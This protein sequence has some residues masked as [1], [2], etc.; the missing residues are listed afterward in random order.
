[1]PFILFDPPKKGINMTIFIKD[2]CKLKND[3]FF[4]NFL[5]VAILKL[6]KKHINLNLK[7]FQAQQNIK[8]LI[9]NLTTHLYIYIGNFNKLNS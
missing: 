4:D 3:I 2:F 5:F 6:P 1:M 7:T 8:L 9:S